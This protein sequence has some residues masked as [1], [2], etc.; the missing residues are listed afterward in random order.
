MFSPEHKLAVTVAE[1]ESPQLWQL[2]NGK[3]TS[4]VVLPLEDAPGSEISISPN[5]RWLVMAGGN[6]QPA[7]VWDLHA[8]DIPHSSVRL[9]RRWMPGDLVAGFVRFTPDSRY[10]ITIGPTGARC[11]PLEMGDLV[12]LA[13]SAAGREMTAMEKEEVHVGIGR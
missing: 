12:R 5:G 4:H 13:K 11:W 7:V 9:F 6:D 8:A 2:E 3:P 1:G 10:L